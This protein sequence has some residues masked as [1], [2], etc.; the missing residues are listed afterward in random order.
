MPAAFGVITGHWSPNN[1]LAYELGKFVN[2]DMLLTAKMKIKLLRFETNVTAV[3]NIAVNF[4]HIFRHLIKLS[5]LVG[6]NI[7][8]N[9][10]FLT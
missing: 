6:K 5:I 1:K 8:L 10:F 9:L 7:F 4:C 3:P 2:S